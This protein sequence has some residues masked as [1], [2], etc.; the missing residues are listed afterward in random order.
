MQKKTKIVNLKHGYTNRTIREKNSVL[1][2][3]HG[4]GAPHRWNTEAAVLSFLDGKFSVPKLLNPNYRGGIQTAWVNGFH[5]QD[6]LE[7]NTDEEQIKKIFISLGDLLKQLQQV[8]VNELKGKIPGEGPCLV[9]G[10]FGPQNMIVKNPTPVVFDWEWAH[11]GETVEDPAWVE[12][13]IRTHHQKHLKHLPLFFEHYGQLSV[14]ETR[15]EAMLKQCQRHLEFARLLGNRK[16]I[17]IWHNRLVVTH[18]FNRL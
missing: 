7:E 14:W 2:I 11:F 15:H 8:D 1:K 12:W 5:A 9:H 10:D 3:Y 18:R 16:A 13:I 17:Q 4:P 6:L